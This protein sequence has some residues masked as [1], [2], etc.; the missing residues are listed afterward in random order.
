MTSLIIKNH[1]REKRRLIQ[2]N[3]RVNEKTSLPRERGIEEKR[4]T[5]LLP[6]DQPDI[7]K[8]ITPNFSFCFVLIWRLQVGNFLLRF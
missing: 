5:I 4:I 1:K 3:K 2:V 6:P 7:D 8:V